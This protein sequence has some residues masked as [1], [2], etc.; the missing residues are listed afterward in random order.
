MAM[1]TSEMLNARPSIPP[2]LVRRSRAMDRCARAFERRR[3]GIR[4]AAPC[5]RPLWQPSADRASCMPSFVAISQN[6]EYEGRDARTIPDSLTCGFVAQLLDIDVPLL[7]DL[8]VSLERQGLVTS[9]PSARPGAHQPRRSGRT[10]RRAL[11]ARYRGKRKRRARC[12]FQCRSSLKASSIPMRSKPA[13]VKRLEKLE[14]FYDRITAARVVVGQAAAP[15]CEG[16]HLPDAH[17]SHHSRRAPMW[18]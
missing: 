12:R 6:N 7:A 10:R 14:K 5:D 1:F 4:I 11:S 16:R 17:P 18:W 15:P 3:R 8:L 9:S 2:F 13:S